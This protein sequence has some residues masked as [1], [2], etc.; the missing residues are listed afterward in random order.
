MSAMP[1]TALGLT[2]SEALA[3]QG[4]VAELELQVEKMR[5]DKFMLRQPSLQSC[6]RRFY[7]RHEPCFC[8]CCIFGN[9]ASTYD[10][11][12]EMWSG[13]P[14]IFTPLWNKYINSIGGTV[15]DGCDRDG[16][17]YD[18]KDDWV[19]SGYGRRP[20]SLKSPRCAVWNQLRRDY[21]SGED[22]DDEE[23]YGSNDEEFGD[24]TTSASP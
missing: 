6:M 10:T 22:T 15:S 5:I 19:F 1:L 8:I 18:Y 20:S 2:C 17:F 4:R 9:R 11:R 3:L 12:K 7:N 24:S 14:C 13:G 21:G 16:I 23:N